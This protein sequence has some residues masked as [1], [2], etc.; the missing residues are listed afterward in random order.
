MKIN[1]VVKKTVLENVLTY[2]HAVLHAR[3]PTDEYD[4]FKELCNEAS[5][6]SMRTYELRMV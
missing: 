2:T 5:F 4:D 1:I 6:Q 3:I